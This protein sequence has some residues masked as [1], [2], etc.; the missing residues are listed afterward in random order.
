MNLRNKLKKRKGSDF[1]DAQY[2][3]YHGKTILLKNQ[4]YVLIFI[5]YIDI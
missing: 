4:S 3:K 2:I 5:R 1:F